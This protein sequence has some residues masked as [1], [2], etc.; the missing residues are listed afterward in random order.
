[1]IALLQQKEALSQL[2][3]MPNAAQ[4]LI[5]Y[6][7]HQEPS[8]TTTDRADHPLPIIADLAHVFD[9]EVFN[10]DEDSPLTYKTVKKLHRAMWHAKADQLAKWLIRNPWTTD[11]KQEAR[12]KKQE[13]GNRLV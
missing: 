11:K 6:H 2:L 8:Y 4:F 5:E 12:N 13:T 7:P 3:A 9:Q 1:M 10:I